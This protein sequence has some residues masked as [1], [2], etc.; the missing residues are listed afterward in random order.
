MGAGISRPLDAGAAG[1]NARARQQ[2]HGPQQPNPQAPQVA[3]GGQGPRN[4]GNGPKPIPAGAPAPDPRI[5][6]MPGSLTSPRGLSIPDGHGFPRGTH[7][8]VAP[9][10]DVRGNF[11]VNE[12]AFRLPDGRMVHDLPGH[13]HHAF[14]LQGGTQAQWSEAHRMADFMG[15]RRPPVTRAEHA[16]MNH[17]LDRV[18]IPRPAHTD[19]M[20]DGSRVDAP[21][22]RSVHRNEPASA[23]HER[24]ATRRE[25]NQNAFSPPDSPATRIP[26]P[27]QAHPADAAGRTRRTVRPAPSANTGTGPAERSSARAADHTPGSH[28]PIIIGD[29]RHEWVVMED[30]G[31]RDARRE[32]G[33]RQD[34][35]ATFEP[36]R[37][38]R[39]AGEQVR[40]LGNQAEIE[41]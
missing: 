35:G 15:V 5:G 23:R 7:A 16:Q 27:R 30:S 29:T 22:P 1:R 20:P 6:E 13:D 17:I 34:N 32:L 28:P 26:S 19:F 2:A 24:E 14:R 21:S 31:Q 8:E 39:D 38:A 9:P 11:P 25:G 10:V 41:P 3:R 40:R 36:P 12:R 33:R 4:G 18:G 37:V